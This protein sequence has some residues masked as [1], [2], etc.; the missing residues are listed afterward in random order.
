MAAKKGYALIP[1]FW[2]RGS[3]QSYIRFGSNRAYRFMPCFSFSCLSIQAKRA[4]Y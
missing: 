1:G 2:L 3:G 4:G